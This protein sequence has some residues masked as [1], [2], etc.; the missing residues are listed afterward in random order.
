MPGCPSLDR[1]EEKSRNKLQEYQKQLS[2]LQVKISNPPP[3]VSMIDA[4]RLSKNP[5]KYKNVHVNKDIL[6]PWKNPIPRARKY[7]MEAVE[8]PAINDSVS[9]QGTSHPTTSLQ[10]D[11]SND[12]VPEEQRRAQLFKCLE[13]LQI[14]SQPEHTYELQEAHDMNKIVDVL[15]DGKWKQVFDGFLSR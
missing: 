6:D 9:G 4:I 1:H 11:A 3:S 7:I 15:M 5:E 12:S 10:P 13:V 8:I 14:L 2:D